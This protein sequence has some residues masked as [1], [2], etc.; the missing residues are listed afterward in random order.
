VIR[1]VIF[2]WSGTLVDDLPAVLGAT[3]R[4]LRDLGFPEL[5]RDEFRARFR[6]PFEEFYRELRSAIP[7]AELE[8]RFHAHFEALQSTVT[9]LPHAREFL[10]F[11]QQQGLRTLV[12]STLPERYYATQSALHG[13]GA[14]LDHPFP[15]VRDKRL[16]IV[17]I[18]HSLGLQ[19][20]ETLF[21][22]DMQHD[23]EAA[24]H[25]GVWSCAVLTGYNRL[26]QLRASEPDLIVE[27][28]GELRAILKRNGMHLGPLV[29]GALL[30]AETLPVATV[31]ALIFDEAGQVLMV[32]TQ[33]WSNRWGIPG[34]KIKRGE[35]AM[36]ALH[37]ELK[38]ETNL[39]VSDVR[40][41]M[42][43]DCIDSKEFYRQAH[44]I[45]LNYT[46]LRR[47]S[48]PVQLNDE[49][50]EFRWVALEEARRLPLNQPTQVLIE[51]VLAQAA[52]EI[53]QGTATPLPA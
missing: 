32:R 40:F 5:T 28:L 12:L 45:L 24:R 48:D 34:G 52:G 41:V 43:Q 17:E 10:E 19:P 51:S 53:V 21:I 46:A 47:G 16:R 23:V 39:E 13:F 36:E 4:A 20:K 50:Q 27:H 44:F 49:A 6:L 37:R 3:N 2:D 42:V 8:T 38:E 15:G 18:L 11:C 22:G 26:E 9:A 14:Y 31:G 29:D 7:L 33:K 25:G 1:N 35:T 30:A